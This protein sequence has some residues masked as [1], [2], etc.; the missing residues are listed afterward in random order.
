MVLPAVKEKIGDLLCQK[1]YILHDQLHE[2]LNYQAERQMRLGDILLELG[3]ITRQQLIEA[4]SVQA[5]IPRINIKEIEPDIRA[6]KLIPADLAAQ[7]KIMPFNIDGN[8]LSVM[9]SDPFDINTIQ[10]IR[11][12]SGMAIDRYYAPSEALESLLMKHYGS[13]VSRMLEDLAPDDFNAVDDSSDI[14]PSM[15]QELARQPSLVNLV[16]I[17]LLEA[18]ED[19]ASDVHIEPFENTVKVKYRIDGSLVEQSPSPKKM[20]SAIVSR[21]K[22]MANM[23]IAERFIPQDGHIEFA[24]PRGKVDIRVSTVPTTYGESITM[25]IL[26]KTAAL[27]DLEELGMGTTSLTSYSQA[28]HKAHGVVLVTGPTGSGKTTTLY[29]SLNE[30]F[31]PSLKIITI[32]DPVEY[33]L[34]GIIQMPV[35]PKRGMTFAKSLRHILRQD[36][37]IIMV[38]EIRDQETADISIRAAMTGHLVF[39]TLHTNNAPGAVTRLIDMGVEPFL[40]ASSLEAVLA[41]RLARRLCPKCKKPIKFEDTTFKEMSNTLGIS[42]DQTVYRPDGCDYCRGSGF[43]GRHGVFEVLRV[44]DRLRQVISERCSIDA[45][46][47]E[48]PDDYRNM[49]AD[50]V[51]KILKGTTTVEEVLRVTQDS[52]ED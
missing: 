42:L 4:L 37:D 26:D 10:E 23:N 43:S 44:T 40:L 21:L 9:M 22:I 50:G 41:Q 12:I 7:H 51:E 14:N 19:R 34:E 48:A 2:A 18:I 47:R 15:L 16:N 32:E 46:V 36:P 3:Y 31:D 24:G 11:M 49:R 38:G 5:G 1:E 8:K 52:D 27:I 13:T 6:V 33:Q 45:L 20:H 30:I 29:A 35:N 28:L 17:I 25:R 39:S